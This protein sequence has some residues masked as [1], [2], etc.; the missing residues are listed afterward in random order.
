MAIWKTPWQNL[1]PTFAAPV[2]AGIAELEHD[3]IRVVIPDTG[4][5]RSD[6]V[7]IALG[8]Q[9]RESLI[10]VN[11]LRKK[12]VMG[13]I[14]SSDN[15][16]TVTNADGITHKSAH[17]KGLAVDICP[18]DGHGNPI[19]PHEDDP[20]WRVIADAMARQGLEN[21]LDWV[22]FQDPPHHQ[23]KGA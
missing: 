16:Y 17:Q 19:W 22:G 23:M 7:Q 13:P 6:A 18:D 21:G 14:E 4:G 15:E 2:L 9:G 3:G 12:A 5:K 11:Q 10:V 20:R 1:D 8:A